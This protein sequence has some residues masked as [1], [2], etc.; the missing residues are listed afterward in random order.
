MT[1]KKRF[2]IPENLAILVPVPPITK[3]AFRGGG[4]KGAA[5]PGAVLA[6]EKL[7]KLKLIDTVAGSS[8]GSMVATFVALGF[9]SAEIEKLSSEMNFLNF[10]DVSAINNV[11][12]RGICD[13]K[14]LYETFKVIINHKIRMHIEELKELVETEDLDDAFA[15]TKIQVMYFCRPGILE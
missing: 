7:G 10:L 12:D 14:V 11:A 9:D 4:A 6:M 3:I 1:E 13:G 2:T 8:A 5:Y 15:K